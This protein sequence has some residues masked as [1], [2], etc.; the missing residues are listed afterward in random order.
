MVMVKNIFYVCACGVC[1]NDL[2][3]TDCGNQNVSEY[4]QELPQSHTADQ[5]WYCEEETQNSYKHM[6]ASRQSRVTSSLPTCEMIAKLESTLRLWADVRKP[7]FG[8][9]Q[10][11][12]V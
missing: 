7:V 8:V 11:T 4:Y 10:T 12:Q 3:D 9:L 1:Y 2:N 6:A 5:S